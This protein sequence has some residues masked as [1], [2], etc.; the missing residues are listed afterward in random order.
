MYTNYAYI[1][2]MD[3]DIV[4]NTKPLLITAA[5]YNKLIKSHVI[6]TERPYGR[7]DFQIIYISSGKAH[8][9]FGDED[10]VVSH[11]NIVLFRPR[12]RQMYYYYLD[13]STESYWIHFTGHEADE[14]LNL[15]GLDQNI[16]FIDAGI[17]S[18]PYC[19][20]AYDLV[21]DAK[22]KFSELSELNIYFSTIANGLTTLYEP[23]YDPDLGHYDS[24]SE[25]KLGHLFAQEIVKIYKK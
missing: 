1:G 13:E 7:G 18:S 17:S 6:A 25:I 11:G 14:L 10:R 24:L 15:S 2:E 9:F 5:G 16:Y 12:E 21:N 8:F 4:D 20:P 3:E 22:V 23:D 19:L